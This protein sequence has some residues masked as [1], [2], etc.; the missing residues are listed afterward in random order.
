VL[1]VFALGFAPISDENVS[2]KRID[3]FIK[4]A[5]FSPAMAKPSLFEFLKTSGGA[6]ATS[7]VCSIASFLAAYFEHKDNHNLPTYF[8][9]ALGCL[10]FCW[11]AY[12]A[13]AN[14]RQKYNELREQQ[15]S[16]DIR[17]NEIYR[18]SIDTKRFNEYGQSIP[19]EDG[20]C[21]SLLMRA[22]NHGH[23]AWSG[24]WPI[25][26]ISFGGKTYR[27]ESTRIPDPPQL[28]QYDDMSLYD[29]RVHGLFQSVW[30]NGADWPHGLPRIGTLSFIAPGVDHNIMEAETIASLQVTFFDSLGNSHPSKF[31]NVP[32]AKSLI[33]PAQK[34]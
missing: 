15:G 11:G 13:W 1:P 34:P 19:V 8:F 17:I 22:V 6:G 12:L 26:E 9:T 2:Q 10:L 27:G 18:A 3:F 21:V 7:A 28:L 33:Q 4:Q 30:V 23:D 20:V 24:G 14:E 25:L 31:E 32:V 5:V 29:R 16:G